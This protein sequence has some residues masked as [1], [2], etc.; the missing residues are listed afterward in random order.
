MKDQIK[1][2]EGDM[3]WLKQ[4]DE[5]NRYMM[6]ILLNQ[7]FPEGTCGRELCGARAWLHD[8]RKKTTD[9]FLK[10]YDAEMMTDPRL[11]DGRGV[12][13]KCCGD[14]VSAKISQLVKRPPAK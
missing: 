13:S 14:Q 4:S 6:G 9:P 3:A 1:T 12:N 11:R 8:E 7:V 5:R 10:R 2:L